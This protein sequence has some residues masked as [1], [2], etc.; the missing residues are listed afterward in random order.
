MWS[1]AGV[2]NPWGTVP[3]AVD[4]Q[5]AGDAAGAIHGALETGVLSIPRT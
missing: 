3:S 5:S 2:K 1:A 4:M